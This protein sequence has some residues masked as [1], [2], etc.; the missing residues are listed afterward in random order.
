MMVMAIAMDE[1]S[2]WDAS[3]NPTPLRACV[4]ASGLVC[5]GRRVG[6]RTPRCYGSVGP[7]MT[8]PAPTY[9]IRNVPSLS[10]PFSYYRP[11]VY[12]FLLAGR[13]PSVVMV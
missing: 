4:C 3:Y 7:G 12:I 11:C 9:T 2:I 8:P 10:L 5:S 6:R 13:S 1:K